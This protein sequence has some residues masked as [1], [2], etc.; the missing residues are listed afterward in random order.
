MQTIILSSKRVESELSVEFGDILPIEI[1]LF[2]KPLLYHQIESVKNISK[3]FYLTIP[4]NYQTEIPN[5]VKLIELKKDLSLIEVL[6]QVSSKFADSEKLF[7]YYGDSLF[8]DFE[9]INIELEYFFLQ[10]PIYGYQWGVADIDGYVPAGGFIF[11]N[12]KLKLLLNDIL[13]FDQLVK[14]IWID[15]NIIKFK[16]FKWLDFGHSLT[17]YNSRRQFLETR[18]FNKIHFKDDFIIK[19]SN[20]I[21]KIWCEYNWLQKLKLELPLNIP[22]VSNFNIKNDFALYS[23]EYLNLPVLSDIFVFGRL[24]EE[25]FV[26]ILRAIK[27]TL[28]KFKQI[29][30]NEQIILRND[31]FYNSKL[32][33]REEEIFEIVNKLKLDLEFMKS[34]ISENISYFSEKITVNGVIHGDLCF[35]NILFNFSTFQPIFID[36]RGYTFKEDGFSLEGPINYDFYKLAHSYVM[37]YDYV[38]SGYKNHS[39]FHILAIKKR[40][41]IF[42]EIFECDVHEIKMGLKHLFITML[43]LHNNS[44]ERQLGFVNILYLIEQL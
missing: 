4:E 36:P 40:L 31:S 2:N 9:P 14:K 44:K 39:F 38:I 20:N 7:I 1:P 22:Y 28:L 24:S 26:K 11:K 32:N 34:L 8:L 18:D 5:N 30:F 35:S 25:D 6:K 37:G 33:E 27:I 29:N 13:T 3:N 19:S 16:E 17:Y 15:V 41:L 21:L 23:I 12:S 43:P 10:K 42:C